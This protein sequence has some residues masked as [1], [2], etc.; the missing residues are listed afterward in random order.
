MDTSEFPTEMGS[1]IYEG[2]QPR[3]DA[4]IV[5]MLK[6]AGATIVGKTTTT[7]FAATDPTPT[8]NPHNHGHTPGGSSSGSAA[9]VGAGMIPLAFGT[10]TGGSVIRPASFCG[11]AAMKPPTDCCRRP[12]KVLFMDPRHA[13][14]VRSRCGGPC[15]RAFGH[16]GSAGP[17]RLPDAA[18]KVANDACA[19]FTGTVSGLDVLLTYSAPGAAPKGL[20]STGDARFNQLWT[21]LGTPCINVPAGLANN[22]LPV[23]MQVIA[24]FGDDAKALAAARFL[25]SALYRHALD[26]RDR[27]RFSGERLQS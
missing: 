8:V 25:E 24:P 13:W 18:L 7:A 15:A 1:P 23:G 26:T 12:C 17:R 10:Q 20:G 16:H 19:A 27:L 21:I 6:R 9:A 14:A 22:G 3:S 2:W 5:T 11:A 4:S